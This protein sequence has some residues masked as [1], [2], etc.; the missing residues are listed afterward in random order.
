MG[1][2]ALLFGDKD[3]FQRIV[4]LAPSSKPRS[5]SATASDAT[6]TSS[7]S[8][9]TSDG[10]GPGP[11]RNTRSRPSKD[12]DAQ[13]L[14]ANAKAAFR[15]PNAKEVKALGRKVKGFDEATWVR[16]RT[17]IVLEGT[18]HK[19][20]Q[21]AELR[22]ELFMTGDKELV[23]ASPLDRVWGIGFGERNAG[24]NRGRWGANLLGRC[25]EDVRG[26]LREEKEK[27]GGNREEK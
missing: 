22:A 17:R 1:Q 23:E 27:A 13:Q 5:N 9:T 12:A 20:R 16:E 7:A 19:F 10:G 4:G 2:K 24:G 15:A 3:V 21:N 14:Q 26:G 11:I 18:L 8:T 6:S 25:V